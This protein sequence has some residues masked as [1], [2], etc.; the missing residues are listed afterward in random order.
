MVAK[1]ESA[2]AL[3]AEERVTQTLAPYVVGWSANS[4]ML[5]HD[6]LYKVNGEATGVI[7]ARA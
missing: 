1:D 6:F 5:S 2:Y 3:N 4:L 7:L